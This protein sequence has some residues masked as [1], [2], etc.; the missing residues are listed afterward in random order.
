[1][2]FTINLS[3]KTIYTFMRSCGYAPAYSSGG[4]DESVFQRLLGGREYPKFH[5]YCTVSPETKSATVNL[6]LDQKQPSYQG[7]HAHNAEHSGSVVEAEA[8]RI[9]SLVEAP[10][11]KF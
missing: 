4:A 10:R 5:A 2:K 7:A 1:M 3:G 11:D 6:H 9:Q 8:A